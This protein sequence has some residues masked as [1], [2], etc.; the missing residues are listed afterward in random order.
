MTV[1]ETVSQI[2]DFNVVN[3]SIFDPYVQQCHRLWVLYSC[4]NYFIGL[5]VSLC[6]MKLIKEVPRE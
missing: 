4:I 5:T 2:L 6:V 1:Y 3:Q